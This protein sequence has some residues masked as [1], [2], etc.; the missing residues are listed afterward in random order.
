MEASSDY[1][2]TRQEVADRLKVPAKTLA[3]WASAGKGPRFARIGKYA[4]YRMSDVLAWEEAQV[5]GGDAA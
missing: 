1:F 2:L 3:V 4:R 5:T